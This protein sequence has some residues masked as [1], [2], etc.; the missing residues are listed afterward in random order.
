MPAQRRGQH[1]ADRIAGGQPRAERGEHLVLLIEEVEEVR[2]GGTRLDGQRRKRRQRDPAPA[3]GLPAPPERQNPP[4][5][6]RGMKPP[7]EGVAICPAPVR[8]DT[9]KTRDPATWPR[10]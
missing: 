8:V 2:A 10:G 1:A 4:G 7:D 5:M 3:P 9:P 6:S